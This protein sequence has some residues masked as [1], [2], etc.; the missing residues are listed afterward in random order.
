MLLSERC[1]DILSLEDYGLRNGS[2]VVVAPR[3]TG[4][5]RDDVDEIRKTTPRL[6]RPLPASASASESCGSAHEPALHA[7]SHHPLSARLDSTVHQTINED[8]ADHQDQIGQ[9]KALS[10]SRLDWPAPVGH[11]E[12]FV[13]AVRHD[14]A[15][16][17]SDWLFTQPARRSSTAGLT[18]NDADGETE[19]TDDAYMPD[20]ADCYDEALQPA[21]DEP[22]VH[23]PPSII[24]TSPP[25]YSLT[26]MD[27]V[28]SF[29]YAVSD[30]DS[31][32]S[33]SE[34]AS[35]AS[36]DGEKV[37][38]VRK[39]LFLSP[40]QSPP[41]SDDGPQQGTTISSKPSSSESLRLQAELASSPR[42][43]NLR[44]KFSRPG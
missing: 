23:Q 43:A 44:Y 39:P 33:E 15:G 7:L 41:T 32:Q 17:V 37:V 9:Y 35:E 1:I 28:P 4:G 16:K 22:L 14:S 40:T 29:G 31:S 36:E 38:R 26:A 30:T 8:K 2:R 34:A 42:F 24:V 25:P 21:A 13:P 11:P 18:S 6:A 19:G 27:N 20:V 3:R 10:A 5:R 12:M